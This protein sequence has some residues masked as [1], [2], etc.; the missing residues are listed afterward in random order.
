MPTWVRRTSFRARLTTLVA[1]AVGLT[2]AV[3]A[4]ASYF[5]VRHELLGQV[6]SSLQSDVSIAQ[7]LSPGGGLDPQRVATFLHRNHDSFLQVIGTDGS[8]AFT[9]ISPP[10]SVSG[11]QAQ[12]ASTDHGYSVDTVRYQGERYRVITEG[13]Y[14]GLNG[15]QYAIQIARPL[16][17]IEHTLADLRTILWL[18]ALAGVAAAVALGY[19]VA[20]ATMRPVER[21]TAAAE[22]VAETQNLEAVIEEQGD[23][24][25]ARL[26]RSFNAMLAAVAASRRQQAQ[27]ISD[28]GHELRTPLTSL[29]TN[30]EVL[31]RVPDLPAQDR[32]ELMA[33][34]N[35][36]LQ[37]LTTLV[38]DVVELARE[39]EV[40]SEPI[41]V[42]F[43]ALVERA[44]ERARRRAPAVV[45]DVQLTPGSVRAQPTLLER[46]VL[47]VLDNAA[48][49]S[50]PDGHVAVWL[51]RG[52]RWTL[53]VRDQGPG[54]GERDLPKVF[55]RFYR[56][57]SARAM[58]GSGLGLA[59]VRQVVESHGG[60]VAAASPPG[61]GTVIHIELPTVV[62]QEADDEPAATT[63][64]R[65]GEGGAGR[66]GEGG[67]GGDV[68]ERGAGGGG[69]GGAGGGVDERGAG[70]GGWPAPASEEGSS[71]AAIGGPMRPRT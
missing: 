11:P 14:V 33:D 45:F 44:V 41:E 47:N 9:S 5:A 4:I 2:L 58:P 60:T 32:A 54:I 16:T 23:D 3:A 53:D 52:D 8:I 29:R 18:V 17:D 19:L 61:G 70:E 64:G 49:W 37:E 50:P 39:D 51:A 67:A 59:I 21:L 15:E 34:V 56:A 30:I 69:E 57:D 7:S 65:G 31:L 26:A 63:A 66:G 71:W 40:Q 6:D 38:G 48:K 68:D 55:D 27:L 10:M 42:R 43:D 12:L 62:E 1:L 36:Q 20:R 22:H 13:G 28:A 25:L 35:A 24:E 46:A